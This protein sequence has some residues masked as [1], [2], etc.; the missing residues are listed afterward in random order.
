MKAEIISVG[1]ELLLGQIANTN[2]RYLAE[3][4]SELGIDLYFITCVGDNFNRIKETLEISR[5]RSDLMIITGGLGPT[6]D[7]ITKETVCDFL[8]LDLQLHSE[9]LSE[10][11]CFFHRLGREMKHNNQKQAVFPQ[12]AIILPNELGTAPGCIIEK[13]SKRYILLPGPSSELKTMFE[14][15]V[16]PYLLEQNKEVLVST[17]LRLF[18]IGESAAEELVSD[19]LEQQTNPT[20]ASLA[21]EAEVTLRITAKAVTREKA[22]KLIAQVEEKLRSRLGNYIYGKNNDSLES[23][24]AQI[25]L[26]RGV[27]ITTAESCTGGLI[28]SQ[29]T[30]IA[31]ISSVFQKA[32]IVYSDR[33]KTELLGVAPEILQKHTAVSSQV[34]EAMALG[35]LKTAEA[36]LAVSSTGYAGPVGEEVGLVYIGITDGITTRS[37]KLKLSGDR[38]RIKVMTVKHALNELRLFLEYNVRKDKGVGR[39]E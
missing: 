26:K 20:I 11:K 1:T 2:A 10:I 14:K 39:D 23:V 25:L 15:H 35:A 21:K 5:K 18:G 34:A 24:L 31:G 32:F 19:I 12:G 8:G 27:K 17:T 37:K 36:D 29:L 9:T 4:L 30:E 6:M 7:D 16:F 38:K 22:L 33:A 3:K 28:S 13:K